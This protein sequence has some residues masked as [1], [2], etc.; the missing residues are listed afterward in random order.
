L[1]LRFMLPLL[2]YL[3][4]ILFG[5]SFRNKSIYIGMLSII[6]VFVQ[7]FGYGLGFFKSTLFVR[8]LNKDPQKQFPNL[9]F[10]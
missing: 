9:F 6:A 3:G 5:S 1:D 7:F 10:K 4:V 2:L 8:I